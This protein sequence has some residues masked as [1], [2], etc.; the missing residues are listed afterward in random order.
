MIIKEI[1]EVKEFCDCKNLESCYYCF[2]CGRCSKKVR[3]EKWFEH[4]L[5][6]KEKNQ[7]PVSTT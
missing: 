5:R 3:Y 6:C 2:T 7:Q 1:S 4:H